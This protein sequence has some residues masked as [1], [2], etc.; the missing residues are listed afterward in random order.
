MASY[1]LS[2]YPRQGLT[3]LALTLNLPQSFY[4]SLHPTIS[5][6]FF[7]LIRKHER[8]PSMTTKHILLGRGQ[9][10]E[11]SWGGHLGFVVLMCTQVH[12]CINSF[13]HCCDKMP[14]RAIYGR[15]DWFEF[16]SSVRPLQQ[17][18]VMEKMTKIPHAVLKQETRDQEWNP[19]QCSIAMRRFHDHDNVYKRK[20]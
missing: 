2:K 12:S 9:A 5:P 14:D 8:K 1:T 16:V 3:T 17:K 19:G 4:L 20:Y 7:V 6:N 11:S 15:K 13:S 18:R 10:S